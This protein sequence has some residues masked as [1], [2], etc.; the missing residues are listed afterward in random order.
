MPLNATVR[1]GNAQAFW[2]DRSDAAAELL[3]REPGLDYLTLDYLAE[4]SMSILA[5]QRE[6]E[7]GAGFARDFVD[8][9]GSLGPYWNSGGRCRLITN[10]GG[11]DPHACAQACA[12][13]LDEAVARPMTIAIVSGDD[14]LSI[15]HDASRKPRSA[16]S[17]ELY[18]NLDSGAPLGEVADRLVTANAYLGAEPLARGLEAGADLVITGRVAD[19]SLT[20]AACL[21]HFGW[22]GDDWH[23]LAGATIAGHL[24]ECGTQVTGGIF[25]DWLDLP[26][27]A[28]IGFPIVEVSADGSCV[29]TKSAG[30][31]GAVNTA[32]V[33]EQLLYEIG[34]PACYRSPDATVSFLALRVED[35]GN[36]RVRVS[37]AQGGP[38][39]P[40]LKLSATWRDGYWAAGTLTVIGRGAVA[41][42]RRCGEIVLARVREAGYELRETVIE[43][44]GGCECG[45]ANDPTQVEQTVLRVAASSDSRAAV[46]RF[47]RELMPLITAGP[48]GVTG[49]AEGRP[50]VRPLFR[51]WPCLIDRTAVTPRVETITTSGNKTGAIRH[52][53]AV[54]RTPLATGAAP[55]T[56]AAADM[57]P[58]AAEPPARLGDLAWA[59]SGDKGTSANIGVIARRPEDYD[60]LEKWLTAE[61]VA[62]FFGPQ[63]V[64]GVDRYELPNLAALNFVLKGILSR[65]LCNDA[66]GKG[67]AQRLLEIPLA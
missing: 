54:L 51:Y 50:R 9:V 59:R 15:L 56:S 35:L 57:G 16:T 33:R 43:C 39:P 11:L 23:A 36:N 7:P 19:P 37:G 45:S 24:I 31:G 21:A 42:A 29:V 26:D 61:R 65:S 46:E 66:Q 1:I 62:Q 22:S 12:Q 20:V 13:V 41:K 47:S 63:M 58:A 48:P 2:G 40:S 3:A 38:A 6:R 5:A 10:A 25:T 30:T 14:V 55:H 49:Y 17:T 27:P 28:H 53:E 4:V 67:L 64:A 44:I 18:R 34:D 52:A 32:T 60:R 8:V